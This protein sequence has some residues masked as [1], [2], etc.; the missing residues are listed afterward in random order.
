MLRAGGDAHQIFEGLTWRAGGPAQVVPA[1]RQCLEALVRGCAWGVEISA[2][3]RRPEHINVLEMRAVHA[4]VRWALACAGASQTRLVL[5]TDSS[6]VLGALLKGRSSS[7][8]L[9]A[10][11]RALSGLLLASGARLVPRW[12]P[13]ALNPA[14]APSRQ[15]M[16]RGSEL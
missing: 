6:A 3:W 14:D 15:H 8:A 5:L 9:L 2:H 16:Q 10:R 1:F 13:S 7:R 11:A 12:V 4:A